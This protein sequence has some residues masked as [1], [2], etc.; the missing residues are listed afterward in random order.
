MPNDEFEKPYD[1]KSVEPEIYKKWEESGFFHPDSL[2]DRNGKTF[3][4]ALPPPNGT[5]SL[6]MGHALNATI[7][8]ILI[9]KKRMEGYNTIWIPA[10]DHAGTARKSVI[11]KKLKKE[12]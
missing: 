4:I 8:D 10:M 6:H 11:E 3:T 5:G 9:R 12:S 2:T 1:P 7:Q